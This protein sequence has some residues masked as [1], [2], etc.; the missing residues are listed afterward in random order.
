[1]PIPTVTITTT[2]TENLTLYEVVGRRLREE[3]HKKCWNQLQ[4]SRVS[5]VS[6]HTVALAERGKTDVKLST[7]ILLSNA[8]GCNPNDLLDPSKLEANSVKQSAPM[9]TD[10]APIEQE[11]LTELL[12]RNR[13]NGV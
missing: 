2:I 9:C 12:H 11:E 5:K 4:L 7:L 10:R 3:R 8:L 6:R 1:M 13:S